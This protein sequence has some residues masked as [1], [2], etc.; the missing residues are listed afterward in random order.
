MFRRL[1]YNN[2]MTASC[3]RK[4]N[5]KTHNSRIFA[6]A[7]HMLFISIVYNCCVL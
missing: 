5:L 7:L 6:F 3:Q 1:I 4:K 2:R